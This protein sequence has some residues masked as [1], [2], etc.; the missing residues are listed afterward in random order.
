NFHRLQAMNT[1]LWLA[2][3]FL[4]ELDTWRIK[5]AKTF[6]NLMLD[7]KNALKKALQKFIYYKL[8]LVIKY[9][10]N[11]VRLYRKLADKWKKKNN[12]QLCASFY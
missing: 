12:L 11:Q 6:P 10:F 9:C 5:L 7:K 2:I 8:A 3:S 4:Y 1:L